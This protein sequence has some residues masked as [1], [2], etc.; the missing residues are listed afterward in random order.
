MNPVDI[1]NLA[2]YNGGP[3]SSYDGFIFHHTGGRGTPQSV[4]DTLNQRGLGTQYVMDRDGTVYRTLPQGAKGAQIVPSSNSNLSNSNTEGMEIIAKNDQDLTPAQ[5]AAA[6][7]FGV[8][9]AQQHPGVQFYGHGMINP[10]HKEPTEG[11]TVTNEVRSAL[12]QPTIGPGGVTPAAYDPGATA[13]SSTAATASPR[14]ILGTILRVES[15]GQNKIQG[16]IGDQN[17]RSGDLA[18]GYFQITD[19]TWR[20]FGGLDTGHPSA[21]TAP[22]ATQLKV[23]SAIP[24][25]R[26]G[27]ATQ[28]ALAAAGYTYDPKQTLGEVLASYKED[29]G[30]TNP[31]SI[32]G[33][34]PAAA[35]AGAGGGET[36][37][38]AQGAGGT[39]P[40][41]PA[42][43]TAAPAIIPITPE[44]AFTSS[45]GQAL[46]S[47][48]T[49]GVLSGGGVSHPDPPPIRTPAMETPIST[50]SPVPA[51]FQPG[52]ISSQLASLVGTQQ[53]IS[54]TPPG[55]PGITDGAPSMTSMLPTVGTPDSY[56]Y[57][58]PRRTVSPSTTFRGVRLS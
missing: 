25:G 52:G 30:A 56:N 32:S 33:S 2:R 45:I 35:V 19:G 50:P 27:P 20:D 16:D 29:P 47:I 26:W 13:A 1:S 21:I 57:M 6:R 38:G 49:S 28:H 4:V 11:Y 43:Q 53:D 48:G 24:I 10:G 42:A 41:A 15:G 39:Q 7:E 46:A 37:R 5:I 36:P 58:D 54:P 23:A 9:Y 51:E 8:G 18:K 44:Q 31:A 12:K 17:N 55:T 40:A 14:S 22:Y 3:L 34:T